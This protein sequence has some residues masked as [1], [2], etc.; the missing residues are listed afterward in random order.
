MLFRL[1]GPVLALCLLTLPVAAQ[2]A[3][4]SQS[5]ADAIF[6]ALA[7][8]DLI[9]IM[10]EEGLVYGR[11]INQ[12]LFPEQGGSEWNAAIAAIY[13]AER[14]QEEVRAA[15][16]EALAGQDTAPMRAFF[17][18][19]PG[20]SFVALEVSARRAL[21]D[22][23][24]EAA[25][26]EI[27]AIAMADATPR[28]ELITRFIAANDLIETNVVGALNSNY[29]FYR[30]LMQGEALPSDLTE[31]QILADVWAQETEIRA[32]TTEWVY[33]FLLMAYQPLEDS[34][35]ETYIAF[36]QTPPG[37]AL[38]R[39]VFAAFDGVF[40]DISEQLGVASAKYMVGQAL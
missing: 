14:M 18:T 15:L 8:P 36:S 22:E 33:S 21:L 11:K 6:A 2:T 7:L 39:A 37:E 35:L 27:A 40:E 26:K 5:D 17:S 29:A 25:S 19:E 28:Y 12:D 38:N 34:D 4:E 10:R 16:T 32:N 3:P 30:G 9:E 1:A 13:D 31:T 20:L 24:V 23:A